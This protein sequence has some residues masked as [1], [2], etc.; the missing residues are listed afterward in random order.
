MGRK[1]QQGH[2]ASSSHAAVRFEAA[3]A[4]PTAF[5]EHRSR[6]NMSRYREKGLTPAKKLELRAI[7]PLDSVPL[8]Y[9]S[10]LR[11]PF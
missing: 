7:L 9:Q 4:N 8:I 11:P 5:C 3:E 6:R 1:T 10:K 2:L